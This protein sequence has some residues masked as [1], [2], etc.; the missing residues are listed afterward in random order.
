[1]KNHLQS[2]YLQGRSLIYKNNVAKCCA[3]R[4]RHFLILILLFVACSYASK[5]QTITDEDFPIIYHIDSETTF[6]SCEGDFRDGNKSLWWE[7][8]VGMW[9]AKVDA[10]AGEV[11]IMQ[12][13]YPAFFLSKGNGITLSHG[14]SIKGEEERVNANVND[15]IDNHSVVMRIN[16]NG[17]YLCIDRF[18]NF[19]YSSNDELPKE[20]FKFSI[21]IKKIGVLS[22][23]TL[24][25]INDRNM[26]ISDWVTAQAFTPE[27]SRAE[28]MWHLTNDLECHATDT[29]GQEIDLISTYYSWKLDMEEGTATFT[30]YFTPRQFKTTW[31]SGEPFELSLGTNKAAHIGTENAYH[32]ADGKLVLRLW[33]I[34]GGTVTDIATINANATAQDV[35]YDMFGRKYTTKPTAAGL[36]IHNGKKEVVK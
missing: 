6:F 17:T 35:W 3:E 15:T 13:Y 27:T 21:I 34:G 30:P 10:S 11:I 18:A 31:K 33:S 1:M 25:P 22:D 24:C 36:Y 16:E 8:E 29:Y 4:G 26:S 23:F 20:Y 28:I 5:A 2:T 12:D 7:D 14:F 32:D 19:D 9:K